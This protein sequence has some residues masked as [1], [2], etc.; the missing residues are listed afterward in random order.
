[1]KAKIKSIYTQADL[2]ALQNICLQSQKAYRRTNNIRQVVTIVLAM[3]LW[4]L[5]VISVVTAVQ[6]KTSAFAIAAVILVILGII[7]LRRGSP[8]ALEKAVWKRY[9]HKD[10]KITMTFGDTDF[11]V[12]VEKNSA[13][14]DNFV[15]YSAVLRLCEDDERFFLFTTAQSAVIVPKRDF[16]DAEAI[17]TFRSDIKELTGL[18]LEHY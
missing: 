17:D 12:H 1:M 7:F 14:A 6:Q 4:L 13:T 9:P 15:E 3:L 2:G 11:T 8:K 16:A 18:A 5:A 10:K